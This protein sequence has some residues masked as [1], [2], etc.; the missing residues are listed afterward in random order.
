GQYGVFASVVTVAKDVFGNTVVRRGE[1]DQESFAKYAYFTNT[2]GLIYF[3]NNDQIYGPV[4]SNDVINIVAPGATFYG[5]VSTAKTIAGRQYRTTK[6]RTE[7]R[8][9]NITLP[10]TA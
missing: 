6:Q 9:E 4:H 7:A 1:I 10:P 5:P 3:A 8:G 2:E